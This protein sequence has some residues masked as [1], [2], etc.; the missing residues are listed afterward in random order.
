M[1]IFVRDAQTH[2]PARLPTMVKRVKVQLPK[3]SPSPLHS[4]RLARGNMKGNKSCVKYV[5][6]Q[7]SITSS[8]PRYRKDIY[9]FRI[10]F[11]LLEYMPII[12]HTDGSFAYSPMCRYH[13]TLTNLQ[14]NK[15]VAKQNA[16]PSA[17]FT[18][19]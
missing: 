13:Y 4:I 7:A 2:T 17:I 16:A 19:L 14:G 12:L 15:F 3:N 1:A 9:T 8:R 11:K 5:V 10:K 6:T 18:P